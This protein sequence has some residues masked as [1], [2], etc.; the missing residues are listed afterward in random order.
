M[1]FVFVSFFLKQGSEEC[2]LVL[3]FLFFLFFFFPMN[4]LSSS[5]FLDVDNDL[6]FRT[7]HL[8]T[9]M[10]QRDFFSVVK[11]GRTV[12]RDNSMFPSVCLSTYCIT[13]NRSLRSL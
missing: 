4:S 13:D 5:S 2:V 8:T 10:S 11:T 9:L 6:I 7:R 12:V 3:S 1:D